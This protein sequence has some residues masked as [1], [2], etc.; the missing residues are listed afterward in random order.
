MVRGGARGRAAA[1]DT[2]FTLRDRRRLVAR[3]VQA[4]AFFVLLGAV[5]LVSG[6]HSGGAEWL[7]VLLVGS[8]ISATLT[9]VLP[10]VYALATRPAGARKEG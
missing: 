3:V 9:Y 7:S 4:V 2:P 1:P 5:L 6:P 10:W 8:I